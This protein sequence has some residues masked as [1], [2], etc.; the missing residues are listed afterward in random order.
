MEEVTKI[1]TKNKKRNPFIELKSGQFARTLTNYMR[2][3]LPLTNT[4]I[5]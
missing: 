5:G 1:E 3:L 4:D 2:Y